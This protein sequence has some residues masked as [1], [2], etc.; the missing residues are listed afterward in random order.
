MFITNPILDE[1]EEEEA[2]SGDRHQSEEL[3]AETG[4][5]AGHQEEIQG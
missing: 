3:C 4:T 2:I 5:H 1:G